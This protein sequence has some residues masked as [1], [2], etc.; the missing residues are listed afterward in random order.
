MADGAIHGH[1]NV[2]PHAIAVAQPAFDAGVALIKLVD[3]LPNRVA[4]Q[5]YRLN[6]AGQVAVDGWNPNFVLHSMQVVDKTVGRR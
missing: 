1:G 5:L 2:G 6:A 3:D 4:A